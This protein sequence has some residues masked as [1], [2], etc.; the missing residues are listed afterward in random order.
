MHCWRYT[1]S[2]GAANS[3]E[4][5]AAAG[6]VE[7]LEFAGRRANDAVADPED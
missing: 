1:G 7:G 2:G 5:L 4:P 6:V 3:R